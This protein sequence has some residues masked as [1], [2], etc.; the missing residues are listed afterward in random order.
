[1]LGARFDSGI[2]FL[3][4]YGHYTTHLLLDVQRVVEKEK[5]FLYLLKFSNLRPEN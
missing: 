2:F 3:Q 5:N 1:M 4:T